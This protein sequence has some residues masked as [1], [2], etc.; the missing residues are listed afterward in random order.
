MKNLLEGI[1]ILIGLALVI[2][3]AYAAIK[4]LSWSV[5]GFLETVESDLQGIGG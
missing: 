5:P 2:V 4:L 1:R 3:L